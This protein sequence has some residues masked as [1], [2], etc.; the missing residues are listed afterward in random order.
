MK[1]NRMVRWTTILAVVAVLLLT[2]LAVYR[3]QDVALAQ[4]G[5]GYD[6]TWSSV[7]GGGWTFS[8]GGGYELGGTAGQPDAGQLSGGQYTLGGGFWG[9][10][11]LSGQASYRVYLPIVLR[12]SP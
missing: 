7:D 12:Q 3:A 11:E 10:G 5:G 6:L 2:G 9:G 4:T 1:T 8:T